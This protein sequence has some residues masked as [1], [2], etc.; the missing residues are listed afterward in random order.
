M[1]S[2]Y[3]LYDRGR[4][5]I[6]GASDPVEANPSVKTQLLTVYD[7]IREPDSLYGAIILYSPQEE[8]RKRL[9]EHEGKWDKAL[10]EL[11]HVNVHVHV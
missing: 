4:H 1:N 5:S 3:C 9:Y 6:K 7:N 2:C 8:L 11:A 10:S